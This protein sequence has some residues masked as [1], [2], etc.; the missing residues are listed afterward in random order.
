MKTKSLKKIS[1]ILLFIGLIL[2]I[3]SW[4]YSYPIRL[5]DN[6]TFYQFFPS[7]WPGIACMVISLFFLGYFSQ[8]KFIQS[9]CASLFPILLYIHFFFFSYAP[10]SDSGNVRGMFHVFQKTGIDPN[11]IPYFDFPIY[12]I[13]NKI[14][15]LLLNINENG[16]AAVSILFYGVLLGLFLYLF[17]SDQKNKFN[18]QIMPFILVIIYFI[19]MYSFLN[20]QWVPQTLAL[21]YFFVLLFIAS[22][23]WEKSGQKQWEFMMLLLF[24][25]FSFTHAFLPVI[26]LFFFA[27]IT[28]KKRHLF[29][30][31]LIMVSLLTAFILYYLSF[32][33][34]LYVQTFLRSIQGF[35]KDYTS[36]V[37]RSF[38]LTT[39]LIN[40]IISFVNRF[41][42][43][44]LW[45]LSAIGSFILFFRKKIHTFFISLG[46]SGGVYLGIG[47]I[48]SILG[49][50]A[51]QILF[52]PLSFGI[53]YFIKNWKKPMMFILIIL[54][55]LSIF[56]PMRIA[57]N[58]T[59]FHTDEEVT[60]C[61]FLTYKSNNAS[62]IQIALSQS[63]NGYLKTMYKYV[64]GKYPVALRPG[65][66][67]F[68]KIFKGNMSDSQ[69][70]LYNSNLAKEIIIYRL[71]EEQLDEKMMKIQANNKII[72]TGQ[73][74]I[75]KGI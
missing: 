27:L 2:I 5:S 9:I 55:L 52:I 71:S 38:G 44:F 72:E 70:I 50:R 23:L 57:Y 51:T 12:F 54:I 25:P 14:Q 75:L 69:Y 68:F 43:P 20:F 7:L 10:S 3:I 62:L 30:L 53:T 36:T 1:A 49:L 67:D 37:S 8:K 39:G 33:F 13:H 32:H 6:L 35:G 4:I 46:L 18:N 22:R 21:V 19:G 34:S 45:V 17:L 42:I 16:I 74:F 63:N 40:Q 29:Y 58:N 15:Y 26:F 48:F 11:V 66:F 60:A 41:R 28:I 64:N 24:V 56:G 73:T 59:H 47:A 61:N 31:F 65:N